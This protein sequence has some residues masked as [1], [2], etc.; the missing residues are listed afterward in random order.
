MRGIDFSA[1]LRTG[2]IRFLMLAALPLGAA[3]LAGFFASLIQTA[4]SI[5]EQSLAFV[6]RLLAILVVLALIGPWI[7]GDLGALVRQMF[8]LIPQA[9]H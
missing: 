6:S 1:L 9:V 3:L 4:F 2:I 7:L 8:A 5:Q